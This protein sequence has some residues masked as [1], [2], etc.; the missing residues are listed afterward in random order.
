MFR[1]TLTTPGV[2]GATKVSSLNTNSGYIDWYLVEGHPLRH[3]LVANR[4]YDPE[5]ARRTRMISQDRRGLVE[6][7]NEIEE[8]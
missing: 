3:W 1:P 8:V 7:S 6:N 2:R 4:L 5:V